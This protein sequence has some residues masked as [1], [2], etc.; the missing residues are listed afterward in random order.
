MTGMAKAGPLKE[1]AIR[2]IFLG[3]LVSMTSATQCYY[4]DGS[5]SND[6]PCQSG[7]DTTWCC[8]PKSACLD[9][10]LCLNLV[11]PYQLSR[12]SCT[13]KSGYGTPEDN[14]PCP[15][16][17]SFAALSTL[18][19]NGDTS[20]FVQNSTSGSSTSSPTGSASSGQHSDSKDAAIGAG[21]GVPLG[22]LLILALAWGFIE[23]RKRKRFSSQAIT[24]QTV[25][26]FQD[27][28]QSQKGS[29]GGYYSNDIGMRELSSSTPT[30]GLAELYE[31]QHDTPRQ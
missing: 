13:A 19:S 15:D 14:F 4:P 11:Q 31:Q 2:V 1:F 30:T 16:Y 9:N 17:C 10:G 20:P 6:V 28:S 8:S 29:Y 3:A 22:V 26:S 24:P 27:T 7:T 5:P 12:G 25:P 18:S 21:V 23:R